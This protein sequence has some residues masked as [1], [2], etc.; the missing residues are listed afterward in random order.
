MTLD[1]AIAAMKAEAIAAAGQNRHFASAHEGLAI[2]Q[3]EFEELKAEVFKKQSARSISKM[4]E[5][6]IQLGAMC[7]RFITDC[8]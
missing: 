6:A 3:E 8:T 5:E 2:I 1:E 4:D 7:L